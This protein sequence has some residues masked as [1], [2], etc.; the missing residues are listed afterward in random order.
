M[1]ACVEIG[2]A[3]LE[4]LRAAAP[5]VNQPERSYETYGVN[6]LMGLPIVERRDMFTHAWRVL[7]LD[8]TFL[9]EGIIKQ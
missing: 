3:A 7:S 1:P 6:A 2:T 8:G 5:A 9:R 4:A